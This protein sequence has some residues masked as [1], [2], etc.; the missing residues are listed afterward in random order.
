MPGSPIRFDTFELDHENFQLRNS[1]QC[2]HLQKVPLELLLLLVDKEGQLVTRREITER[3]WGKDVFLDEESAVN[4]AIRK[5]R[6][7]LGDDADQPKYIETVPGKGY[8]FIARV[9]ESP[10][11]I[12]FPE[13][14]AIARNGSVTATLWDH[15]V[16]TNGFRTKALGNGA[17]PGTGLGVAAAPK[18]SKSSFL[19]RWVAIVVPSAIVIAVL[20]WVLG[21][22]P[23]RRTEVAER[24]LTANS[25]ENS[26]ASAAISPDAKYL[27][28]SD[29]TGVYLKLI[30][31]GETHP[32]SLPLDFAARVDDWSPEGSSLLVTRAE[33]G[34]KAS[35]WSVSV[36]GGSPRHLADDASGGSFS[37]DGAHIAFR[38]GDLTYD[39]LWGREEWVMRSDGTEQVPVTASNSDHSQLGSPTWSPDGKRIA[40]IRSNWAWNARTSSIELNEWQKASAEILFSDNR[41]S[42]A[43]HW[44]PDGRIIYAF[45]STQQQH[46]SSLWAATLQP[47]KKISSLPIRLTGGHGWIS[48]I[49]GS[50]DGKVVIFLRGN[51]LP[52]VYLGALATDGT[53]LLAHKRLTLDE[54]ENDTSAWTPDSKAVLFTS[55][56]NGTQ[57]IFKQAIDQPLPEKLVSSADHLSQPRVTP[58]GSEILYISTPKS[59]GPE[60]VS[61]IFAIP[62]DGGPP[63]LVLKDVRIWNLHCARLPS[64]ICLYSITKGKTSETFRFDVRTGKSPDPPQID[65]DCNWSLSPDG[66]ER[67]II[68]FGAN[69]GKIH[70]RS[71]S[72]GE[73]RDLV[74]KGWNEL[75][76]AGW[77]ADGNSLLVSWHD[78]EQ[79][80][81]LLKV[82]L[83]G[84]ASVL[85]SSSNPEVWGAMSSPD[86]RLLAITEA[87]GPKNVWQIENF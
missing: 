2:V 36:F 3:I 67:A 15:E 9:S 62:R 11:G 10:N 78:F 65:P 51:W 1:G 35:L 34:R 59:P 33:R 23:W 50:A 54:N 26:V 45:G 81:A 86:G 42:P 55:D 27:A 64:N 5:I 49:T 31:T 46:D 76:G 44:L 71:T 38:R 58:D 41:L 4:T 75:M 52:S 40:Y 79:E 83:D 84:K 57:E 20:V 61:S 17:P 37:P 60:T 73:T 19:R 24:Q 16:L 22:Y 68:A 39:C 85:L 70:L 47:S 48:R 87:G 18:R 66:S 32:V 43:L 53:H 56:R 25:L 29:S 28:F 80:S 77:S 7:A 14:P 13:I 12:A 8:R 72:T 63:R 82:T 6:V 30:R 74:V 21:R 69:D